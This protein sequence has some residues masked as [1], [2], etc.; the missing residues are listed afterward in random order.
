MGATLLFPCC[1]P[2]ALAYAEEAARRG[3]PIV[4]ASSL[5]FDETAS[6]FPKWFP[7]PAV[8]ARTS[9]IASVKLCGRT[10]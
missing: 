7:L 8:Y 4:A 10:R 6:Q 3:E 5:T 2:E 1:V 9:R